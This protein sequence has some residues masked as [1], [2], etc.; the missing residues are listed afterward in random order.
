MN[1]E[2]LQ[3]LQADDEPEILQPVQPTESVDIDSLPRADALVIWQSFEQKFAAIQAT[4]ATI[5]EDTVKTPSGRAIVRS[6]RLSLKGLRVD[7]EKKRKELG[8]EALR[9][10]QKIDAAAKSFIALVEPIE[11]R[12]FE[13]EKAEERAEEARKQLLIQTRTVALQPFVTD[14]TAYNLGSMSEDA[15]NEALAGAKAAREAWL[16]QQEKERQEQLAKE[17]AEAE[18]R[19]RIRLENERLKKEAEEREAQIKAEREEAERIEAEKRERQQM[20]LQEIQSIQHQVMIARMGRSGVRQG[21]S[22]ECIEETLKETEE[23]P[24]DERFGDLQA[25]AESAKQSAVASMKAMLV[26]AKEAAKAAAEAQAKEEAEQKERNRIA[27]ENARIQRE[28]AEKAAREKAEVEAKAKREKAA[29]AAKL[30]AEKEAR[31]KI[32]A[33]LKAKKDAEETALKA[34]QEAKRKAAAAPDREKLLALAEQIK[35]FQFPT[36]STTEANEILAGVQEDVLA[37]GFQL[38]RRAEKL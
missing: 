11:S 8:E 21:G 10:K 18:E 16:A 27:A 20:A 9:R 28:A 15:F 7:A 24:I 12:L 35:N 5:T 29:A 3:L 19:E 17:K 37:I 2:T 32:E 6:V 34:E 1:T 4:A 23:W 38:T 25:A 22:I 36:L 14:L 31:E 30:K 33:E 26:E 13:L